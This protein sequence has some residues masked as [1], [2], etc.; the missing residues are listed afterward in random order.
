M[1]EV[2]KILHILVETQEVLLAKAVQHT[3]QLEEIEKRQDRLERKIGRIADSQKKL[4]A[5][6]A[7]E[8]LN[9]DLKS[10]NIEKTIGKQF[11]ERSTG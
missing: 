11:F 2:K 10:K 5:M 8:F 7:S 6:L 1:E 3:N 9:L 4:K